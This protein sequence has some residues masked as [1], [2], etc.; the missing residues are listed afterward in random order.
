MQPFA[1]VARIVKVA[2]AVLFGV[3]VSAP[4]VALRVAQV[5]KAPALTAK[6]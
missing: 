6:V 5:G 1:S 2:A 4:V 3:P